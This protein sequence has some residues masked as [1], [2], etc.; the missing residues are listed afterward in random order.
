MS[1]HANSM[2]ASLNCTVCDHEHK[3]DGTCDCGC[4]AEQQVGQFCWNCGHAEHF[5]RAC[6]CGC[7]G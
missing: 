1:G 7:T 2:A 3:D 5:E 6:K 4:E